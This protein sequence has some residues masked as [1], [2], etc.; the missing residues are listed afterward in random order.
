MELFYYL[1][2]ILNNMISNNRSLFLRLIR[3]SVSIC[4]NIF[5]VVYYNLD[6]FKKRNKLDRNGDKVI[7][8][9]TSFPDRIKT[10]KYVIE[11]ILRQ[12]NKPNR[13]LLWLSNDQFPEKE[14]SLPN[15]LLKLK[16][17]GLEIRFCD[18]LY[19]HKKYYYTFLEYPNSIIITLDD[20]VLYPPDTIT[21][22]L[23]CNKKYPDD[24]SC[25]RA[26]I[27]NIENNHA[28][29][30]SSWKMAPKNSRG[31]SIVPI[32]IGGVLYPPYVYDDEIFNKKSIKSLCLKADDLWLKTMTARNGRK[33][34]TSSFS[35]EYLINV[36]NTQHITLTS[37]NVVKGE[38]NSQLE[39]IIKYYNLKMSLFVD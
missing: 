3:K 19:S 28:R 20:D 26:R 36:L 9:L 7:V 33:S 32:G 15:S 10:L 24:V 39:N 25:N 11:T 6:P 22:L 13:L 35:N 34:V 27:M 14:K 17:R 31:N 4:A 30:Y 1:I 37:T 23:E 29:S 8:S 38:N 16:K 2:S 12:K 18:E 21:K 5:A